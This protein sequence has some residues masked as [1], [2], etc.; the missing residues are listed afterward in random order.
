MHAN[1]V[2]EGARARAA[3]LRTGE[4]ALPH[5]RRSIAA[6][7]GIRPGQDAGGDVTWTHSTG[8]FLYT[9]N[10]SLSFAADHL[11]ITDW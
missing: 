9:A 7:D 2:C 10:N 3:A 1:R 11:A 8:S 4:R 6:I 5:G